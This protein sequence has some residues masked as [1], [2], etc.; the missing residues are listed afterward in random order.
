MYFLIYKAI[1]SKNMIE[2]STVFYYID[3]KAFSHYNN[4]RGGDLYGTK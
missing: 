1:N 4:L 3:Q 2:N